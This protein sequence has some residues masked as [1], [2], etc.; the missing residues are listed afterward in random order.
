[1]R[2]PWARVA[3]CVAARVRVVVHVR[4]VVRVGCLRGLGDWARMGSCTRKGGFFKIRWGKVAARVGDYVFCCLLM[5]GGERM[6]LS[7]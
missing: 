2:V 7:S 5:W 6:I 1:M 3:A 4:V